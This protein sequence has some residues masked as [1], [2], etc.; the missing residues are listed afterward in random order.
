M[1]IVLTGL[2]TPHHSGHFNRLTIFCISNYVTLQFPLF[3]V[4][5]TFM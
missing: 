4:K 2:P 3:V 1:F 5:D